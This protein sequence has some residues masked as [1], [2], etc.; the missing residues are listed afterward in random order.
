MKQLSQIGD[1]IAIPFWL[2]LL[3]YFYNIENKNNLEYFLLFYVICGFVAD[4]YF[5]LNFYKI[6]KKK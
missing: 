3:Y 1:I 6:K 2:L 4:T 5:T